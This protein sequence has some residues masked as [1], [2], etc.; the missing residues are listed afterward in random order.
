M[1]MQFGQQGEIQLTATWRGE[2]DTHLNSR[3]QQ[4]KSSLLLLRGCCLLRR[5]RQQTKPSC[6]WKSERLLARKREESCKGGGRRHGRKTVAGNKGCG[7]RSR[8][9]GTRCTVAD[10]EKADVELLLILTTEKEVGQ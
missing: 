5:T 6:R 1:F 7:W 4:W 3:A 8:Q 9:E 2:K 10:K